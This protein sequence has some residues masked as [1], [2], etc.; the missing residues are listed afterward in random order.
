MAKTLQPDPVIEGDGLYYVLTVVCCDAGQFINFQTPREASFNACA[1]ASPVWSSGKKAVCKHRLLI[2]KSGAIKLTVMLKYGSMVR[3]DHL[4][5]CLAVLQPGQNTLY[6]VPHAV[7]HPLAKSKIHPHRQM[8]AFFGHE[9]GS[10]G[11][12]TLATTT[13]VFVA[14]HLTLLTADFPPL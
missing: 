9:F 2:V 12:V 1:R 14:I 10:L 11:W 3:L 6:N 7:C 8:R 5:C 13:W 4:C